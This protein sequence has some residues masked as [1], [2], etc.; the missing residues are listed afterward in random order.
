MDEGKCDLRI[1]CSD[2]GGLRA[3]KASATGQEVFSVP[4]RT[5]LQIICRTHRPD[6][7][8]PIEEG[9]P[10][11]R[12]RLPCLNL[13]AIFIIILFIAVNIK[14]VPCRNHRHRATRR[15]VQ[16]RALI[17]IAINT[18]KE[19]EIDWEAFGLRVH[20]NGE[21]CRHWIRD[22]CIKFD[23]EKINALPPRIDFFESWIHRH[24]VQLGTLVFPEL[25]EIGGTFVGC[26]NLLRSNHGADFSNQ[27]SFA[28]RIFRRG[29]DNFRPIGINHLKDKVHPARFVAF[30]CHSEGLAITWKLLRCNIL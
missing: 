20:G 19:R 2:S 23:G 14:A 30:K 6:E 5:S 25:I 18:I 16:H 4:F 11:I 27:F 10:S 28:L 22:S 24:F 21:I 26:A 17:G 12:R 29:I 15:H 1:Q 9:I 3:G 8:F 7:D 13:F